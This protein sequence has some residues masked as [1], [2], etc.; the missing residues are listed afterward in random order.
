[1]PDHIEIPEEEK[2]F[3]EHYRFEVDKGQSPLRIDKFL[4]LRI[5]NTSRNKIQSAAKAGSILV[6]GNA[7]KQNYKVR[8][9]DII[10]IVLSHPPRE[11]E[12]IPQDIPLNIVFEDDDLI[13]I[14]KSPGMVVHP[15]F[16][17]Y[18][19]T[20]VNA[21][22]FHLQHL[23]KKSNEDLRPGLV[24]RI[25]KDTSGLMVIAKNEVVQTHLAKQFFDHT[26]QRRYT[27]L[28]WGNLKE[29]EGTIEGHIGRDFKDRKIMR[30]YP[31]GDQGKEAI[32]HYKVIERL[33]YVSLVECRLETGRTH[34][35][36]AHMK[37]IGHPLFNDATY[38]GDKILKGTTFTKY[39]Q[40]VNNCFEILPRQALH[41]K[42]LGFIHP[43]TGKEIFFDSDLP[44][45][46]ATA[47][48]KWRNYSSYKGEEAFE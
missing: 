43:G 26:I 15:G 17:N 29:D 13:I 35:I 46:M 1:M 30:V 48:E 31:D 41:A 34:Q 14:N 8:P 24:H 10:S 22:L 44:Q 2:D 9:L 33:G 36:R 37:Y 6:N 11:V 42:S 18:D 7:A 45:D 3:Y 27:A 39:K 5:E 20:L 4:M 12:L 23:P 16:N 40:F 19:G 25:D 21:L 32:T 28:V 38:G 47:I